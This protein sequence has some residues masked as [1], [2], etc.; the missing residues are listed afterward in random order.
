M[1]LQC[2]VCISRGVTIRL[3]SFMV[4]EIP[5]LVIS[6]FYVRFVGVS[7]SLGRADSWLQPGLLHLMSLISPCRSTKPIQGKC[8]LIIHES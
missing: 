2:F 3:W 6:I 8:S 1:P 7:G 5:H 4:R